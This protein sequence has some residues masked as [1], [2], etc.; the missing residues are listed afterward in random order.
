MPIAARV[1]TASDSTVIANR[2]RTRANHVLVPPAGEP[3]RFN[4][5]LPAGYCLAWCCA[6]K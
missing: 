3:V 1:V 5:P 2:A 6:L 4:D